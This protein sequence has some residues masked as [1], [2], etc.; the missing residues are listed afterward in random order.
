MSPTSRTIPNAQTE[1][2]YTTTESRNEPAQTDKKRWD[3]KMEQQEDKEENLMNSTGPDGKT[4]TCDRCRS[5][6][7]FA[8]RWDQKDEIVLQVGV[9]Y[10][11]KGNRPKGSERT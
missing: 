6:Y 4:M 3:A 8:K 5:V 2:C 9:T 11:E 10:E 1:D 7:H